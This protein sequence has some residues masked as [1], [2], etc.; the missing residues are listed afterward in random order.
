MTERAIRE[1]FQLVK[2]S[3]FKVYWDRDKGKQGVVYSSAIC[4]VLSF[5]LKL[6]R[7]V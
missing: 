6:G 4:G 5:S 7:W 2:V 3:P 1:I